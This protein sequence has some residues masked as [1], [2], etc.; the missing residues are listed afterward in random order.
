MSTPTA[1]TESLFPAATSLIGAYGEQLFRILEQASSGFV[2]LDAQNRAQRWN[3]GYLQLFPWLAQGLKVGAPMQTLLQAAAG[4]AQHSDVA[5]AHL[6]VVSR[7]QP[8]AEA[9]LPNGRKV[10]LALNAVS[11]SYS[12]LTCKEVV[13]E[14][15]GADNLA[16]FDAMTHLPNRR[17]LLDRL[18]QAMIQSERTGW[19]GALLTIDMETHLALQQ[20]DGSAHA[21]SLQQ[22]IAQRLL[23]CM[24]VCDTVAHV[25]AEHFVI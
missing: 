24:R 25:D 14:T 2:L 22:E 12:L 16:F 13:T 19:R 5:A 23:G 6:H 4:M 21:D 8:S 20:I 15:G 11:A 3:D 1:K 9:T 7:Q 10:V 18:S 17:L